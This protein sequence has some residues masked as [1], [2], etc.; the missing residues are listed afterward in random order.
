[1][2]ASLLPSAAAT[3]DARGIQFVGFDRF[4]TFTSASGATP[5]E[6]VLTSPVLTAG[7]EW[8]ELIA[9]WNAVTPPCTGL[10]IE[11]RAFIGERATKF[12][13]MGLWA[14]D[15]TQHPRE[16]VPGQKD[17][18]GNVD[19]DTLILTQPAKRFQLRVTLAGGTNWPELKFLAAS[20]LDTRVK[21]AP[22]P[23]LKSAWGVTRPVPERSQMAY[24]GGSA[25]CSP[26]TISML[27]GFWAE[28]LHRP[29]L[30]H[31]TPAVVKEVFDPK[32]EGTGNWV[33][34]TAFAGSLPGLRACTLRLSDLA[35]AEAWIA[36]GFP[37]GLSLCYNRLR[38]KSRQP[39][40]HLVVLVG[41][42][43]E[44]DPIINDPGTRKNVRK[45][46]P[47]AQLLD[48][49]AYSKNAAY[50][51]YPAVAKLPDDRWGHWSLNSQPHP[52]N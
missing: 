5:G 41:F 16:S 48:A 38:A 28:K 32:W 22:L 39:S 27:L 1:M 6:R 14:S 24:E 3:N 47:R 36:R 25:W 26:T 19:T 40:G 35:E 49:W 11:V 21:P 10:R 18:D 33:F 23:P 45:V 7:I 29:E 34:N 46:F 17:A 9:S 51:V 13:T 50:L 31:L 15:A 2:T 8:N 52:A 12:Y 44:G 43:A 37:V 4:D 30:D 42:T 20:L